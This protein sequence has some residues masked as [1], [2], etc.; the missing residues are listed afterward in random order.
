[1]LSLKH[2]KE[3]ELDNVEIG[4]R[5]NLVDPI[6]IADVHETLIKVDTYIL[7]QST[8]LEQT[9]N[10]LEALKLSREKKN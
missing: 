2:S 8:S 9:M 1:M 4:P 3:D 7:S 5:R 6:S 10:D